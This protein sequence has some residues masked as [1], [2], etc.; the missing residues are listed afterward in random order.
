M[1]LTLIGSGDMAGIPVHGCACALCRQARAVRHLRRRPTCL[2]LNESGERLLVDAGNADLARND[3]TETPSA[4]LVCS[5]APPHWTGLVR[6]HLGRGPALPVFGPRDS[7][8]PPWLTRTAGQLVVQPVL[9][10]GQETVVGRF[11]VRPFALEGDPHL[12]GYGI[13]SGEQRLAYV[14]AT[15]T[16]S[17]ADAAP[18]AAWEPQAVVLG[19][20][21]AG[22]AEQR[23]TTVRRLHE[24][25]GR[26]TLLLTGIDHHLDQWL[27]RHDDM[28][29]SGIRV[30]RDD[31]RLDMTY[32]NEYRR[33]GEARA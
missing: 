4:V 25:L 6:L 20:P 16:V 8:C 17:E 31:Q 32:L 19:C 7:E 10:P 11:H 26:P 21:A 13:A 1:N 18:I 30:A 28:L 12:L 14:P 2:D 24:L 5:W 29:P 33:L 27:Q 15:A 23:L 3:W 22:H 9:T